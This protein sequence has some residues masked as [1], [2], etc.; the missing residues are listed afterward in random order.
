MGARAVYGE[1]HQ[2]TSI[3]HIAIADV[4]NDDDD[5]DDD[6]DDNEKNDSNNNEDYEDSVEATNNKIEF[7]KFTMINKSISKCKLLNCNC[8]KTCETITRMTMDVNKTEYALSLCRWWIE[9]RQC[10][11]GGGA[12]LDDSIAEP[13]SSRSSCP[14]EPGAAGRAGTRPRGPCSSSSSSP[15]N[16]G[17]EADEKIETK[18]RKKKKKKK[19]VTTIKPTATRITSTNTTTSQVLKDVVTEVKYQ[20]TSANVK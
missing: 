10:L 13:M 1:L 6:D 2:F 16:G 12:E 14:D 4:V 8:L 18:K 20:P 3:N 11:G 19:T 7:T 9:C 17:Q 5:D 15:I